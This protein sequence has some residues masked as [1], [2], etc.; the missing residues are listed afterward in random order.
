MPNYKISVSKE[1][2]RFSIF[3]K[4]ENEAVAR[5]RVH[6][7]WYSVLGV[8]EISE[9]QDIWNTFIF[10]AFKWWELKHWKI[11]WE[12]IFKV[13]VKLVKNLEYDVVLLYPEK[14]I[15]KPKTYKEKIINELKEEYDILYKNK[16]DKI[17]E[18]REKIKK[19]KENNINMEQFYMKK[20]LE[21]TNKLIVHVLIKLESIITGKS[22]VKIDEEQRLKLENIYNS[23]I[24]LKKSTNI[25]KLKEIWELALQ[26][27]WKL[28]LSVLEETKDESIREALKWSNKLLK[29]LGSNVKFVEKDRDIW[30]QTKQFLEYVKSFFDRKKVKRE[31][32]DKESYYYVKNNRYLNKYKEKL[33]ENNYYVF[34][35][36]FKLLSNKELREMNN[37][38]RNVI[39]QNIIIYKAKLKWKVVSYSSIAKWFYWFFWIFWEILEFLRKNLFYIIF[40]FTILFLIIL[41]LNYNFGFIENFNFT[42]IFYLLF[43]ILLYITLSLSKNLFFKIINFAIFIFI[44]ILGVINF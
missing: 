19:E 15:D 24:K 26:K 17:D 44:I 43:F 11:A 5:E 8:E 7:E 14:D 1:N 37:L 29:E 10:E 41:N 2:K 28:E 3:F 6:K 38:K 33:L 20:E 36:F 31:E 16:K 42:W 27:I 18:L 40:I 39:K 23:I 25:A 32:I 22:Q 34:K 12:D 4:A 21:E 9:F 30:Y 13:Y 35:N